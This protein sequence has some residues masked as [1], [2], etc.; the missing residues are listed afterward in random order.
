MSGPKPRPES[1]STF[2][3]KP[4][5]SEVKRESLT[6][7]QRDKL[8]MEFIEKMLPTINKIDKTSQEPESSLGEVHDRR[9]GTGKHRHRLDDLI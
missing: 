4:W 6:P 8:R 3:Q 5:I 7:A 9:T 2:G 1:E